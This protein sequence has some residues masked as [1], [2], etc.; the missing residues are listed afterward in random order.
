MNLSPLSWPYPAHES[1]WC[2]VGYN[3]YFTVCGLL[4]FYLPSWFFLSSREKIPQHEPNYQP[5]HS[6]MST[7]PPLSPNNSRSPRES[8]L[9]Y[10]WIL[11]RVLSLGIILHTS[12]S[13]L[14]LFKIASY[15]II[16]S[17]REFPCT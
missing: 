9:V 2:K 5:L 1:S 17:N 15:V 10:Q 16:A 8:T 4:A 12:G 7:S 14:C 3:V 13:V 6:E 11:T